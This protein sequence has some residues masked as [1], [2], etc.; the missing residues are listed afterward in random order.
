M[1]MVICVNLRSQT[2]LQLIKKRT[3]HEYIS[4]EFEWL[5]KLEKSSHNLDRFKNWRD[6]HTYLK[7]KYVA[8][9]AQ[10]MVCFFW[11]F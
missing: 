4:L 3:T 1:A 9:D 5:E 8:R 2:Q 11:F 10:F 7:Q 6:H